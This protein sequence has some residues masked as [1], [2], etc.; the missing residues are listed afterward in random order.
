MLVGSS[1][2]RYFRLRLLSKNLGY[3]D[4][5]ETDSTPKV[6]PGQDPDLEKQKLLAAQS[7]QGVQWL[8]ACSEIQKDLQWSYYMLYLGNKD[9]SE[10]DVFLGEQRE[11]RFS[12]VSTQQ[13]FAFI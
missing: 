5:L 12:R 8:V 3:A 10:D 1:W 7:Q 2:R 11:S 13:G 6:G 9:G 4:C